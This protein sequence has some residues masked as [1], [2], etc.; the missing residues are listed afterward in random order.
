MVGCG[1]GIGAHLIL[2]FDGSG[3]EGV[4]HG[5]GLFEGGVDAFES[6]FG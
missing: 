6:F 1:D 4:E 2:G 5:A 3:S